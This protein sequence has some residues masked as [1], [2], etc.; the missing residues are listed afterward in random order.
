MR[1]EKMASLEVFYEFLTMKTSC[2]GVY[3][4]ER[5]GICPGVFGA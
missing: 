4:N 3:Q 2:Q 1:R 5:E